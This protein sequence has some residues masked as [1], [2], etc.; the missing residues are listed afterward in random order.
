ML[1]SA[2]KGL[3][4]DNKHEYNEIKEK[5]THNPVAGKPFWHLVQP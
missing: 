1:F 2:I 3:N 4:K 5:N